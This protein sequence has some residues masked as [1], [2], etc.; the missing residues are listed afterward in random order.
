LVPSNE[1]VGEE[2]FDTQYWRSNVDPSERYTLAL[3]GTTSARIRP[4]NTGFYN[5]TICGDWVDNG[6]YIGAA[7]GA[8]ISGMLAFRATTGQPLPIAGESF[9]YR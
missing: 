8:V 3:P 1:G 6:F 7:E 4:D 5:L 2:R 9:W